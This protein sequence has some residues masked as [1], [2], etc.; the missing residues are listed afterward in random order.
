MLRIVRCAFCKAGDEEDDATYKLLP[1]KVWR[2][3]KETS[4]PMYIADCQRLQDDIRQAGFE[5]YECDNKFIPASICLAC[6]VRLRSV[7]AA[8]R[9]RLANGD[10]DDGDEKSQAKRRPRA[11]WSNA[12]IQEMDDEFAAARDKRLRQE[13]RE[14]PVWCTDRGSGGDDDESCAICRND[15]HTPEAMRKIFP[16]D[17]TKEVKVYPPPS[18]ATTRKAT[19]E[20]GTKLEFSDGLPPPT[21]KKRK[22]AE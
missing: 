15:R 2:K 12:Q 4:K 18:K 6:Q 13:K 10:D 11:R 22:P 19:R 5:S 17:P 1:R 9:H 7:I 20:S 3:S 16:V 8:K 14:N 21:R